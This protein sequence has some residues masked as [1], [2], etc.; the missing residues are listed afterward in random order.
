MTSNDL[1][2]NTTIVVGASRGLGRGIATVLADSGTPVIAVARTAT[3]LANMADDVVADAT[4]P[5]SA[6]RLIDRY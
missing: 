6:G 1:S 5:A 2:N 3:G 4:N